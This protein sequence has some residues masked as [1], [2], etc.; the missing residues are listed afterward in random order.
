MNRLAVVAAAAALVAAPAKGGVQVASVS[1]GGGAE[2]AGI[3]AGD[4]LVAAHRASSVFPIRSCADLLRV[5]MEEAPRGRVTLRLRRAGRT[6][7]VRLP[8]DPWLVSTRGEGDA[9]DAACESFFEARRH[10]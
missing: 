3:R 10:V 8:D 6:L 9:G 2:K 4:V 7:D 1:A 5:E